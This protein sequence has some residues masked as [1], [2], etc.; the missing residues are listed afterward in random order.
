LTAPASCGGTSIKVSSSEGTTA[1][2][3][4][5]ATFATGKATLTYVLKLQG[6]SSWK[7][8]SLRVT[9]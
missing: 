8:S 5:A 6:D 9:L 3:T 4:C 7:I 1:G 2:V